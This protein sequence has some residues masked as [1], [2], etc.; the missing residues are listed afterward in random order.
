MLAAPLIQPHQ[1]PALRKLALQ[2]LNHYDLGPSIL[3]LLQHSTNALYR[4]DARTGRRY[5]LR[6]YHPKYI[7]PDGLALQHRFLTYLADAGLSV[8]RPLR[9]RSGKTYCHVDGHLAS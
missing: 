5:T 6:L 3:T 9:S 8:P 4:I 7:S 2:A 1:L